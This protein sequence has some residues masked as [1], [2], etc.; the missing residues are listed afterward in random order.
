MYDGSV[1]TSKL[2]TIA[3]WAWVIL[4][5]SAAWIVWALGKHEGAAMLGFT[6]CASSAAAATSQI[7]CYSLRVCALM[8]VTPGG[9]REAQI[10]PLR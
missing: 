8:R 10:R 7:R 5:L 2:I 3:L 4:L 9:E 1:S 6:A